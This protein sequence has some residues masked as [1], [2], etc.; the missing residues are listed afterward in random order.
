MPT[1]RPRL[2]V[3]ETQAIAQ[4]LDLA[5]AHFPDLA[6]HRTKLLLRL[7]EVGEQ[8]LVRR[9]AQSEDPRE[10]AKQRVLAH[11][12]AIGE[13]DGDAILERRNAAW[14]FGLDA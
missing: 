3:T 11:T 10:A 12:G 1:K 5:A 2:T 4:R 13:A 6:G 9:G 14:H 7:T 8:A